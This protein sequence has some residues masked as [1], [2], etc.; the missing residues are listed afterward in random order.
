VG[1]HRLAHVAAFLGGAAHRDLDV[2]HLGGRD[3]AHRRLIA[4]DRGRPRWLEARAAA[5]RQAS[6]TDRQDDRS[7]TR[8][9]VPY[10][11]NPPSWLERLPQPVRGLSPL[12]LTNET[13]ALRR[14]ATAPAEAFLSAQAAR[15]RS[16][17]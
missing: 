12:A 14:G 15:S 16:R 2:R 1:G 8:S 5:A 13:P 6:E 7:P 11:R 17:S 4:E 3:L 9:M 10:H